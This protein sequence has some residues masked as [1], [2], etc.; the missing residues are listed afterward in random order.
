MAAF[1]NKLELNSNIINFDSPKNRLCIFPYEWLPYSCRCILNCGSVVEKET[2]TTQAVLAFI[3]YI[4]FEYH[5]WFSAVFQVF[6]ILYQ[7]SHLAH[8]ATD[9]EH[10]HTCY[11]SPLLTVPPTHTHTHTHTLTQSSRQ[12]CC[13]ICYFEPE[14]QCDIKQL[15]YGERKKRGGKCEGEEEKEWAS[16]WRGT[17]ESIIIKTMQLLKE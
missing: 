9:A 4:Y 6:L 8:H 12:A 14:R 13:L 11:M 7:K 15:V 3:S 5:L 16:W 2:C 1:T 17:R 10:T